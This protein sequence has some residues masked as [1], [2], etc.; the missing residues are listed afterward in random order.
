MSKVLTPEVKVISAFKEIIDAIDKH[1]MIVELLIERYKLK[2]TVKFLEKLNLQSFN[3]F[4]I[5][6]EGRPFDELKREI[7]DVQEGL[8]IRSVSDATKTKTIINAGDFAEIRKYINSL[9][10]ADNDEARATKAYYDD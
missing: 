10:E 2:K 8:N 6:N 7:M 4:I 3:N 1:Q 5:A 9:M